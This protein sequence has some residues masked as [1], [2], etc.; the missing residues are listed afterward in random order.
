VSL[1]TAFYALM[2]M[3]ATGEVWEAV[4]DILPERRHRP[5]PI[6]ETV[7]ERMLAIAIDLA[8]VAREQ[9]PPCAERKRI[10]RACSYR[11]LCG[12]T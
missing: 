6:D 9:T 12:F 8:A 1:Q 11:F 3:A 7:L 4:T 2:L 10:C 5:V